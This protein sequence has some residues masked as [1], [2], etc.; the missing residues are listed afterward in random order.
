MEVNQLKISNGETVNIILS[1][2]GGQGVL[3]ASDII[4]DVALKCG[5]DTKKS[6]V[7]GMAQRGGSVLS[8]V[9]YGRK[10]YSPLITVGQADLIL[11]FEKL[12]AV[13]YLDFLKP[14]GIVIF[15]TQQITPLTVYTTNTEYTKNIAELCRRKTDHVI[16]VDAVQIAEQL[17]NL[18]VL[19]SV[20]LG[21]LSR[22]LDLAVES[23]YDS[24]L[25]R[26]PGKTGDL[27]KKAFE[28]GQA[29]VE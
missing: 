9:R 23:W 11:A 28:Q 10:I 6:E 21:T 1:G 27:N 15:N 26:V 29:L 16:S 22:F 24:I 2:V 17:G 4:V 19:N 20:M 25:N 13:R 14:G 3:V 5:Y 8:Q 7:H 12:E 18:K